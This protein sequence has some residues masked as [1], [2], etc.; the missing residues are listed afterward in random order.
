[1]TESELLT[2]LKRHLRVEVI[3]PDARWS[4]IY[5]TWP[6]VTVRLLWG[7]EVISEQTVEMPH[8]HG[9]DE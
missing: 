7:D 6:S 5:P 4:Y 2:V 3:N 9:R 8:N 1:M